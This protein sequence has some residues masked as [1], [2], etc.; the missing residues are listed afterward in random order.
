MVPGG[1]EGQP[2][3]PQ[4]LGYA[5]DLALAGLHWLTQVNEYRVQGEA[6]DIFRHIVLVPP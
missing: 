3:P 5:G 4:P 2:K 6:S 1:D